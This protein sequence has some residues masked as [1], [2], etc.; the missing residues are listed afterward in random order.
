MVFCMHLLQTEAN[1]EKVVEA[2]HNLSM[3]YM[4]AIGERIDALS[5]SNLLCAWNEVGLLERTTAP[6]DTLRQLVLDKNDQEAFFSKGCGTAL[7]NIVKSCGEIG[8]SDPDFISTILQGMFNH[9]EELSIP[10]I[11]I[12]LKNMA[13]LPCEDRSIILDHL[14]LFSGELHTQLRKAYETK[15]AA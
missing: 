7:V 4:M 2:V 13:Q 11:V 9:F 15:S 8:I 6:F 1:R 10:W 5:V 14:I 12:L 3:V